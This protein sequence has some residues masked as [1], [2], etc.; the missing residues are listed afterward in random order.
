MTLITQTEAVLRA[1]DE[2]VPAPVAGL[3]PKL[4]N[5]ASMAQAWRNM[6]YDSDDEEMR[7]VRTAEKGIVNSTSYVFRL[8]EDFDA[9]VREWQ[10]EP[11]FWRGL[12]PAGTGCLTFQVMLGNGGWLTCYHVPHGA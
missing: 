11:T 5:L 12:D 8:R 1:I 9:A 7:L 10:G 2:L 4:R 3:H 6:V